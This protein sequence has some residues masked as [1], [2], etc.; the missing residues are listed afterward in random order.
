MR[1]PAFVDDLERE[2]R[3]RDRH[4]EQV[5]FVRITPGL[6]DFLL[7]YEPYVEIGAGTGAL[8]AAIRAAGGRSFPT[9]SF[10]WHDN[11]ACAW[12]AAWSPISH[13][14]TRMDA[15][16]AVRNTVSS[17][18]LC[19]WP[20]YDDDWCYRAVRHIG[21]GRLFIYIGEGPGGCTGCDKLHPHIVLCVPMRYPAERCR[22]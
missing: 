2:W 15:V 11:S 8:S 4:I 3:E 1:A 6:I 18:I 20:S 19:S 9:D 17:N 13:G 5:G 16:A 12:S 7:K 21:E 14:V 10:A 22:P